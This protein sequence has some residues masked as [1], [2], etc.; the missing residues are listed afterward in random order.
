MPLFVLY[1]R[2]DGV[3]S[4]ATVYRMLLIEGVSCDRHYHHPPGRPQ[5]DFGVIS[6]EVFFIDALMPP[7]TR[8]I[9][10]GESCASSSSLKIGLLET[11]HKV[12]EKTAWCD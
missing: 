8:G 10:R 2:L 3:I 6:N 12:H 7:G 5:T 9:A 4:I 1:C 11:D